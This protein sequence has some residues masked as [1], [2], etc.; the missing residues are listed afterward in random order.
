[1]SSS[2]PRKRQAENYKQ[3]PD[4]SSTLFAS[5]NIGSKTLNTNSIFFNLAKLDKDLIT[6]VRP[7]R[8]Q[9]KQGMKFYKFFAFRQI[10]FAKILLALAKLETA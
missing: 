3:V 6:K 7:I 10:R 9:I 2:T 4:E 5:R 8:F 1:M